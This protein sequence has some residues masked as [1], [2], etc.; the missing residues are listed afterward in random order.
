MA[1]FFEFMIAG[2]FWIFYFQALIISLLYKLNLLFFIFDDFI[3]YELISY[4][5]IIGLYFLCF[6]R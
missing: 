6:F 4:H 2:W 1:G 5:L 3:I